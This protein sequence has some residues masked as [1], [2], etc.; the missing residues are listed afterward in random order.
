MCLNSLLCDST[1]ENKLP[2]EQIARDYAADPFTHLDPSN[3]D[4]QLMSLPVCIK[5]WFYIDVFLVQ[6]SPNDKPLFSIASLF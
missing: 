2:P 4:L 1:N 6:L 5:S 3:S